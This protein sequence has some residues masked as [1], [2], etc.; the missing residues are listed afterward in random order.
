MAKLTATSRY[1]PYGTRKYHWLTTCANYLTGATRPEIT[2]ATELTDEIA[3]VAGF[4]IAADQV[5]VPDLSGRFTAKIPGRINAQDSSITF[6]A[7]STGADVRTV[8]P[9]DTA[10]YLL[11]MP[12]G[13]VAGQKMD[14]F[15]CKVGSTYVDPDPNNPAHVVVSFSITKVPAQNLAIPA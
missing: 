8:L 2:A 3:D 15:P 13:D 11:V 4:T 14:I 10:G 7:S 5:E 6:Y 1:V 12:E 9:R